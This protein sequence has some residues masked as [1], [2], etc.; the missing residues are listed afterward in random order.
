MESYSMKEI[1]ELI[2]NHSKDELLQTID[3][4]IHHQR[5]RDILKRRLLDGI[6][7]EPLAEEFDLTP[8]QCKN[9]VKECQEIVFKHLLP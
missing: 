3:Q 2:Q 4:Y 5:N 9:I 1:R 7:F 8:R 6:C